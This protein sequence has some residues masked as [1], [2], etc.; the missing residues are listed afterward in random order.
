MTNPLGV[1]S[2]LA[3]ASSITMGPEQVAV[4]FI[5]TSNIW[6][7]E[8]YDTRPVELGQQLVLRA[9]QETA[10]GQLEVIVFDYLLRGF[11]SPFA[12][13]QKASD[14]LLTILSSSKELLDYCATLRMHIE[15]VKNVIQ[16]REP[17]LRE[18]RAKINTPVESYKLVV[19]VAD[20]YFLDD[21]LKEQL[22][23]LMRSGPAA[24]VTFL[25][26]SPND[27]SAA[28]IQDKGQQIGFEPGMAMTPRG[29][30]RLE[31]A[32]GG[33][34]VDQCEKIRRLTDTAK[35]PPIRFNEIQD[36]NRSWDQDSSV[37]LTF[38]IGKYGVNIHEITLGNEKEQRHNA[39]VTGAVG[40]GKSNLVSVIIHSLCQRYSPDEL[41][42]YLLDFKEGVTLEPFSNRRHEDYLPHAR[43]LG[44]ESDTD[45]GIA[46]L[47]HL[48][49]LYEQRMRLFK[50][51]GTQNLQQYRKAHPAERMP[52]ILLIIDEF[53]MMFTD[54]D[55]SRKVAAL[56]SRSVRLFRAAGIHVIL[57]SQT[58]SSGV[59]LPKD[60]DVFAQVP[61]RIAL[62]NSIRE[63]EATLTLGNAAATD[64]RMGQAI[65]NLDYGAPSSNRKVSIALADE[66]ELARL[67]HR[68]WLQARA[69]T[70]A[71]FTFDGNRAAQVVSI[72][73]SLLTLR[74]TAGGVRRIFLGEEISVDTSAR[75]LVI[76]RTPGRNLAILGL[77]D[78]NADPQGARG[79]T[80]A[81]IGMLQAA[82]LALAFQHPGGDARFICLD[83]LSPSVARENNLGAF[84]DKMMQLGFAV[85]KYGESQIEAVLN[86]LAAELPTR[87]DTAEAVYLLG[88]ALD[89][90]SAMPKV[91]ERI[92]K[93]GPSRG[94][95]TLSWWQKTANFNA[96]IGF[97]NASAFDIKAILRVDSR[98]VSQLL[99]PFVQWE[100]RDNRALVAD[101]TYR[102]NPET[103]IPFMPLTPATAMLVHL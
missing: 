40:Q 7:D 81:A 20:F 93:E 80:N 22:S 100:V 17:S 42:L 56:L 12:D 52:R 84:S 47:E 37:G 51:A 6:I 23:I 25:I 59:D 82:G 97:G 92:I 24:G 32:P 50:D 70:A 61:I 3:V 101:S 67:R 48:Y 62:K 102:D 90:L 39:L 103:I 74:Q 76:D 53:Q 13:L 95:H 5:G 1:A 36:L 66:D 31:R 57:A 99:G 2:P 91:F 8:T 41:E 43:V 98:E 85:E 72:L 79:P 29:P 45:F 19:L 94:I 46:V 27:D 49:D 88:F 33:Y 78:K 86:D 14:K 60:S 68:W 69:T 16:A 71:P 15:G 75:G 11:I 77:G 18:F 28:Q 9:L 73:P 96:H 10:P 83:L 21:T 58:I 89:R 38:A 30:F 44:L 26:I 87:G 65:V 63:S 34:I 4:D 64:L 35:S 55:T 54:R